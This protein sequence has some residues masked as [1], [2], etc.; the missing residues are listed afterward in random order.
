MCLKK[1]FEDK[2]AFSC[3]GIQGS[4]DVVVDNLLPFFF[5]QI[6]DE[7]LAA[8]HR[9]LGS[10]KKSF[11]FL[12]TRKFSLGQI[13]VLFHRVVD[14]PVDAH[15]GELEVAQGSLVSVELGE[16]LSGHFEGDEN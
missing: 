2:K 12:V 7:D 3:L 5:I 16:L 14:F 10:P 6:L 1:T 15:G 13:Q 4:V 8:C 9:G 11:G